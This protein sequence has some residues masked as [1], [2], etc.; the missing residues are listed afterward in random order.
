MNLC[1]YCGSGFG[2][3]PAYLAATVETGRLLAAEGVGVIYGGAKI[4]LMGALADAALAAGGQVTGVIPTVLVE[5]EIAHGG[6][7][8][9]HVVEGMH[10]R[11][12][13]MADLSDGFVALPGGPGTLDEIAEQ[14]VWAL[15][16]IHK[17]PV[18]FLN[19]KGYFDPLRAMAERMAAEGFVSATHTGMLIFAET[20][21][22]LLARFRAY[23]APPPKF[24][25]AAEA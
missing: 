10:Q 13:L 16:G 7:T 23:V 14:W 6:L 21:A 4:G 5:R 9:S 18:G 22:E 20:P 19:I 1:V 11:K 8:Q 2:D 24:E 25:A 12:A 3:D 17:K 15:L